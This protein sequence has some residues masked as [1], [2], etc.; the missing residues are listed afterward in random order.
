MQVCDIAFA[1]LDWVNYQASLNGHQ[2]RLDAD[3]RFRGVIALS[4][5]GVPNWLDPLGCTEGYVQGRWLRS[6]TAPL[7][8]LTKVPLATLREHLP[9]D[10]PVV[11]AEA[12]DKALRERRRAAQLRRLY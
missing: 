5:P 10:T 8:V 3:G 2:A 7:P 1:G 9:A 4:D 11:T 6:E 12:R